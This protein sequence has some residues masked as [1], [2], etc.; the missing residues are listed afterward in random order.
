VR[1]GGDSSRSP[2]A[3]AEPFHVHARASEVVFQ[4]RTAVALSTTATRS[5]ITAGPEESGPPTEAV[6]IVAPF[7]AERT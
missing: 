2:G 3:A 6:Q 5:P 7:P 4:T 1:A